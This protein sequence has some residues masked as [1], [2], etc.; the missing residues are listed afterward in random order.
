M[1][2]MTVNMIHVMDLIL[3]DAGGVVMMTRQLKI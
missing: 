3:W 2:L 1:A